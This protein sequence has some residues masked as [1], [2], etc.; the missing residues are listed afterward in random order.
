MKAGVNTS[1][2]E[3]A[4]NADWRGGRSGVIGILAHVFMVVVV[5]ESPEHWLAHLQSGHQAVL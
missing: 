3:N 4:H 1:M 2:L 5:A